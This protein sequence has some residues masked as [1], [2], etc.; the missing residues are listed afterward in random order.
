MLINTPLR[1][2]FAGG[3]VVATLLLAAPTAHAQEA[4]VETAAPARG[5]APGLRMSMRLEP[6]VAVATTDPQSD[7]TKAG[8]GQTVKLGFDLT[9]YLSI[10]PSA[11]FTT[12]PAVPGMTDAGTAWAF[13][14]GARLMRPHDAAPGH[15]GIYAISPWVDGDLLYVRTG[16]LSRPGLAAAVGA[17]MPIDGNRKFWIGPYARYSQIFQGEKAG[18]DNRDAKIMTFGLSLEVG[19]G[20]ERRRAAPMLAVVETPVVEAPVPSDRDGDGVVDGDDACPD[21]AGLAADHGC[22]PAPIVPE[23]IAPAKPELTQHIAFEWNS[24][25]LARGSN[26]GLDQVVATMHDHPE[27]TV[28]VDGHASSDGDDTYNQSLSEARADAVVT[29][30]VSRGVARD[31]LASRG[32]SSSVPTESNDTREG[33]VANRRVE[34][35]TIV[36]VSEGNT[37]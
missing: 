37:P 33:R 25:R 1:S 23:V 28:Q 4:T 14:G 29:Y 5:L 13:G 24:S 7:M 36:I 30:L 22:P 10:G 19:S 6:G 26:A 9:R 27:V 17:S 21:V 34:F 8:F 16:D 3:A 31:R 35:V 18:F 20:L 32:F 15:R 2:T 11:T 12:L